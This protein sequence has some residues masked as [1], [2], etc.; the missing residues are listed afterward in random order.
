MKKLWIGIDN[1]VSG[2]LGVV[3]EKNIF[4]K[5]PTKSVLKYTKKKANVTRI[6]HAN[7]FDLLSDIISNYS[8][9]EILIGLERPMVN[10][11]RF[12]ATSSALRAWESTLIIMERLSVPYIYIDS[13]EWQKEL[14]PKG[15][16]GAP[17]LKKAS[18]QVGERLFPHFKEVKHEDM[19]GILIAEYLKRTYS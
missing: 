16:K 4:T 2:T 5:V 19:D 1:G 9:E 18:R 7:F 10:P 11:K 3:G 8:S 13:K 17:E 14:L 12:K 15:I 6:D